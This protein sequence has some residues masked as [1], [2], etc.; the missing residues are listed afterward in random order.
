[1]NLALRDIRHN[2]PRF[3][4]TCLGL[5]MLLGTVVIMTGIYEGALDDALRLPRASSPD[6]WVVQPGTKGPFAEPS[7]IPRDTRDLVRRLP[8]VAASGAVTFQ[9]VQTVANGR[10]LR[11]LLQG[12]E[13][14]RLGGPPAVV[15][16]H[17]I[18]QSHYQI[19]ANA[20]SGLRIDQQVPLGPYHDRFTVVGLTRG[21]VSSSG[22]PVAWISLLDAQAIQFAVPP[23]LQR[24]ERAAGR[25]PQA[26]ADI[27]AVLV[28]LYPG[29]SRAAVAQDIERWKHLSAV[30]QQQEEAFLTSFVVSKQSKTLGMFMTILIAVSAVIITLIIYTLTMDKL[31]SIATLKLVGAPDRTIVGLIIQQALYLGLGGFALGVAWGFALKDYLFVRRVMIMPK[32]LA[33]VFAIVVVVCL[34]GSALSVRVAVKVDPAKAL[35]SG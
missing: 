20:S 25:M 16:G 13:P 24:R 4:L 9:T 7:R 22:D 33:I 26:T 5:G 17:G 3:A 11:L 18:A 10:P 8:G 32:D 21:M 23:A 19:V 29:V 31:R 30:P 12:Y 27:N 1:M 14:G 2:L 28:Q 35:A 15:A 34:L 6:L